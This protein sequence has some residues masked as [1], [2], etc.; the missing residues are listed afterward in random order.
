MRGEEVLCLE[1]S[2]III[3]I[4]ILKGQILLYLSYKKQ[5]KLFTVFLRL[6]IFDCKNFEKFGFSNV[7]IKYYCYIHTFI[8]L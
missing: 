7:K 5:N 3:I 8:I 6:S 2:I 4:I 1:L